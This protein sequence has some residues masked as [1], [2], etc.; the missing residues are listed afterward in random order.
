MTW[1]DCFIYFYLFIFNPQF[2]HLKFRHF[3]PRWRERERERERERVQTN[4]Q[5]EFVWRGGN[6]GKY[7]DACVEDICMC[8]C[9][10]KKNN[11][12][13]KKM[14]GWL[15]LML[16]HLEYSLCQK[17]RESLLLYV[18]TIHF[19]GHL[20]RKSFFF[21]TWSYG[22]WIILKDPFKPLM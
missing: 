15:I 19:W 2:Q 22:I 14:N 8:V 11:S 1:S 9:L 13:K 10:I 21:G 3:L 17:V 5:C 12:A 4:R 7:V 6:Y 16:T 18:Y 20:F